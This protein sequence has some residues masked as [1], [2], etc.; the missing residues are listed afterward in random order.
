M[1]SSSTRRSNRL[2][3]ESVQ[4]TSLTF[5]GVYDVHGGDGFPLGVFGVRDGVPDDVFEKHLEH[6]TGFLVDETRYPLDTSASGQSSY[7]RF[8]DTLD[9]IAKNFP[10]TLGAS[11][12]QAF[13]TFTSS[14]HD[15]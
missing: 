15:V 7:G 9:V 13:A 12:A 1:S 2:T 11:L 14:G 8:R 10:M 3:S 6:A 5:Q 4:G